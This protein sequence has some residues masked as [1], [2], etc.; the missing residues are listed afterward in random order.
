M[1][2]DNEPKALDHVAKVLDYEPKVLDHE[3]RAMIIA[4]ITGHHEHDHC[5][6]RWA[7]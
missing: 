2:L 7:S 6:H 4:I 5:H 3:P 1:A